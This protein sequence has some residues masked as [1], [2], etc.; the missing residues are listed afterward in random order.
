MITKSDWRTVSQHFM[1]DERRRVGEPPTAEEMLAYSRGELSAEEEARVRERLVCYPELVRTLTEPFPA[2]GAEPGDPDYL[3]DEDFAKHWAS[4]QSRRTRKPPVNRRV[5]FWRGVAALAAAI[6]AV[7][8]VSLWRARE[9][10]SQP[11]LLWEE[12]VLFP[13]GRRGP[14]GQPATLTAEGDSILLV[15]PVLG[16]REFQRYRLEIVSA[17]SDR[18][19]WSSTAPHPGESRSF[20]IVVP[21]RFLKPGTLRVVVHGVA[22][23]SEERLAMYSLRVPE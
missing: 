23:A 2:E 9:R 3:S 15:V 22:G 5:Q 1:A 8:G 6:I 12:Q 19:L 18:T 16:E 13:D 10:L 21:R 7:L 20:V 17:V 11:T 4:L 14:S